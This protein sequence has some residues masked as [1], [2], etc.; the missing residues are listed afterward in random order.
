MENKHNYKWYPLDEFPNSQY[1][2]NK[3]GEIRNKKTGM[4]LKGT[5]SKD[6]YLAYL[7]SIDGKSYRRLAHVLVA[8]QFIPNPNNYP[9]VNHIDENK[10][11]PCV[12]NLEWLTYAENSTHGTAQERSE[13]RR[14]KPIS[15]Y[16]LNGCYLRT[17][18]SIKE[19]YLYHDLPYDRDH[20]PTYLVKILSNNDN[21]NL[22]KIVFAGSVLMRYSGNTADM[23]FKIKESTNFRNDIYKH[24][25]KAKNVPSKYL[26][27]PEE[28]DN[29]ASDILQSM[30]DTN[31][32]LFSSSQISA[33][34][35]AIKCIQKCR[36]E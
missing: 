36:E 28:M 27:E 12:D 16:D 5:I 31:Q 13:S 21:P 15:E 25:K 26:V 17:W 32:F 30:I 23:D 33:I 10:L 22:P 19:I 11:N 1:E 14:S 2:I 29:N 6:G 7:L 4:I 9:I 34:K 20:R 3:A 8:K 24:L 35:F 18:K